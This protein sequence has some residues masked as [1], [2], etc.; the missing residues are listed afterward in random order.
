MFEITEKLGKVVYRLK[1]PD[2]AKI[3]P[4]FHVSILKKLVDKGEQLAGMDL[5]P[6]EDTS[7]TAAKPLVVVASKIVPSN[8]GSKSMVMVQWQNEPLEEASWE[9]WSVLK[10]TY[11]LE[12][13]AVF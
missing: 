6:L 1:L 7:A 12:E 11:H 5:P 8:E 13:K 9:D 10:D 2:D 4:V 3:H